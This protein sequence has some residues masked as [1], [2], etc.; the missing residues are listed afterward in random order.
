MITKLGRT[1]RITNKTVDRGQ[2]GKYSYAKDKDSPLLFKKRTNK[3]T[4]DVTYT[5]IPD[6]WEN[7][8][9]KIKTNPDLDDDD[10]IT[11]ISDAERIKTD[12]VNSGSNK[13]DSKK[14]AKNLYASERQFGWNRIDENSM[15]SRMKASQHEK[16][17]ANL[18]LSPDELASYLGVSVDDVLNEN[19]W[20]DNLFKVSDG[21]VYQVD[22]GYDLTSAFVRIK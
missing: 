1:K 13:A 2:Y 18:G 5:L 8:I 7:F 20:T 9:N 12:I 3:I 21:R 22:F 10:R 4:G 17:F 11:M 19:L 6:A 16:L 14:G 15:L